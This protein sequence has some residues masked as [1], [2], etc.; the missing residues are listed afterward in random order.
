MAE[1]QHSS[2]TWNSSSKIEAVS[3][4]VKGEAAACEEA[5]AGNEVAADR[6]IANEETT[7]SSR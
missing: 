4:A 6:A 3:G 2:S 7:A 1:Q 5:E